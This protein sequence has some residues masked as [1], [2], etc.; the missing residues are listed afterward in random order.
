MDF[1]LTE[2]LRT[3][4]LAH[5]AHEQPREC[6]GLVVRTGDGAAGVVYMPCGNVSRGEGTDR[7]VI[8]PDGYVA[9]EEAGEVLAVVHSHPHASAN[10]SMADRIGCE[11][12]GLPWLI[13]GW[14]SGVVKQLAPEGWQAPYIGREFHHGVLDCYTLIQDWYW[15]E[16]QIELPDFDRADDWWERRGDAPPQDLYMQGFESAGFERV[17]GA[18]RRHDVLLMQIRADVANHGAVYLG[19]RVMLH[20]LHSRLSCRDVWG[21]AWER[22]TLAVLRHRSLLHAGA[23]ALAA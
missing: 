10:P 11:R 7:F 18:P 13:V 19:D 14:P 15:R 22:H 4:M 23:Q 20:H 21:G 8:D 5:A 3:D 9:A 17:D 16:L 2:L 1:E 6:C 12:S